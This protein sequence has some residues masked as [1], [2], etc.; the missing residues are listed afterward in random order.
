MPGWG[1]VGMGRPKPLD[2]PL[3]D[4]LAPLGVLAGPV[5][6][7]PQGKFKENAALPV[8]SN[9]LAGGKCS[10]PRVMSGIRLGHGARIQKSWWE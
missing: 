5:G 2:T 9:I 7:W 4:F 6:Y 8:L 3:T 1:Q 10:P